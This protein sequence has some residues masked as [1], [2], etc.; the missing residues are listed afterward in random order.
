MN[1]FDQMRPAKHRVPLNHN[2]LRRAFL[3]LCL[4]NPT[5]SIEEILKMV[6]WTIEFLRKILHDV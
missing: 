4:D 2:E 6:D 1:I 5:K 3:K